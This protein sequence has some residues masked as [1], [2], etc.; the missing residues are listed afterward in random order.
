MAGT[1]IRDNIAEPD[2]ATVT[3]QRFKSSQ[4]TWTATIA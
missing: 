2:P 1:H 3:R 4:R